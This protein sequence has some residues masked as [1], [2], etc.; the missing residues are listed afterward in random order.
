MQT[1]RHKFGNNAIEIARANSA[2]SRE[3]RLRAG[4]LNPAIYTDIVI[5]EKSAPKVE[6]VKKV[7]KGD[8]RVPISISIDM[9]DRVLDLSFRTN[10]R[11][12]LVAPQMTDAAL[13]E[14]ITKLIK[15]NFGLSK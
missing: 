8:G 4:R 12:L 15:D 6:P 1:Y 11:S 9:G 13:T 7:D 14:R 5:E 2:K 3:R 10:M